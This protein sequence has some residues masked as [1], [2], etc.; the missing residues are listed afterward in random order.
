MNSVV[1]F[2]VTADDTKRAKKFYGTVF[3]WKFN[4]MGGEYGNYIMAYTAKTDKE[5]MIQR[6][7]A[8]NGGIMP[9]DKTAKQTMLTVAITNLKKTLK[10]VK[11][12]GGK[13]ISETV[14]IPNVGLYS[15]IQDTEGNVV[16]LM[17]PT[18]EWQEKAEKL[19]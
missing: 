11:S 8:I 14:E 13:V 3:D 6:K 19:K 15:R 2:E 9:K 4:E 16:S 10:K 17:E 12:N 5:G 1:H 18:K 7:G